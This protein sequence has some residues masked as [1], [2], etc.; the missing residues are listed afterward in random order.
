[1]N[2][3]ANAFPKSAR[4]LT[5]A[6]YQQVFQRGQFK[7]SSKTVLILAITNEFSRPRLGLVIAKKNIR[8]AV[9]RN[10]VKRLIRETFRLRQQDMPALDIV[11]LAR[12]GLDQQEN[13]LL[14]AE[15][16]TLWD[17]L[18]NRANTA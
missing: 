3:P 11:V 18:L 2:L 12:R 14:H 9:Q 17:K 15:L 16:N 7:V 6:D 4:L 13:S 8:L 5:P 1:M 10:R